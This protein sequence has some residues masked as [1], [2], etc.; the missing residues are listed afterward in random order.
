LWLEKNFDALSARLS[1]ASMGGAPWLTAHMCSDAHAQR[2]EAFF[3]PRVAAITGGPRNLQNALE[4]LHLCAAQASQYREPTRL[5][6]GGKPAQAAA[7]AT[8]MFAQP[9]V[10]MEPTPVAASVAPSVAAEA[11][12]AAPAAT[13]TPAP[14][15]ATP[16]APAKPLETW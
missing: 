8:P 1:A 16:A 13:P 14:T 15:P 4:A 10:P 11:P 7:P 3:A 9:P 2:M 5:Y 6:F 12:V